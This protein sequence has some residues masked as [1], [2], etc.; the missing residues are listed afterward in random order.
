M[1]LTHHGEYA[2][3]IRRLRDAVSLEPQFWLA[4]HLLANALI[5][6][7]Q[8]AAALPESAEAKRL[9]PLQTLSDAFAAIALA[10]LGRKHEA[11]TTLDSLSAAGSHTY[12]P[13]SHL[14]LIEAA[15]GERDQAFAHLDAAFAVHDARLALLKVDPKWNDL[16]SDPRFAALLRRMN[17]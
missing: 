1:F 15:L 8:Y 7:G 10:R 14:A 5:D 12:I 3:A 16:R 17:F 9:S 13:P 6:A 11:R 4:H 2:E